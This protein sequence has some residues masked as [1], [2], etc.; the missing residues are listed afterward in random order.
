MRTNFR[1]IDSGK[2]IEL[3]VYLK[4]G[5]DVSPMDIPLKGDM[6]KD[7]FDRY[8]EVMGRQHYWTGPTHTMTLYLSEVKKSQ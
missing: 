6:I 8:W 7:D 1:D 3:G 2:T 5:A 4:S